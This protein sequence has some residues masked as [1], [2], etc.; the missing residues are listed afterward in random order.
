MNTRLPVA[1]FNQVADCLHCG[2]STYLLDEEVW[3]YACGRARYPTI[4]SMQ[5]A[6]AEVAHRLAR[7][8]DYKANYHEVESTWEDKNEDAINLL[9]KGYPLTTVAE[10][11]GMG[12]RQITAIKDHL[13]DVGAL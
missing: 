8:P 9:K 4:L 11:T 10:W 3:C 7:T 1:Q 12:Y 6:L 5:I 2:G 13:Q